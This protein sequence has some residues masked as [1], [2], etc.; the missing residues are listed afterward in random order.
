MVFHDFSFAGNTDGYWYSSVNN[1]VQLGAFDTEGK[2]HGGSAA[3]RVSSDIKYMDLG[4]YFATP[5]AGGGMVCCT[6]K[7][8]I[9]L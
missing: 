9:D 2:K 4:V 6:C 3:I 7:I 1:I 8:S 5:R